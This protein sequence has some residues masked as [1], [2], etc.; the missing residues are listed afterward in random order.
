MNIATPGRGAILEKPAL[1]RTGDPTRFGPVWRWVRMS[2]LCKIVGQNPQELWKNFECAS[3]DVQNHEIK[4]SAD[5]EHLVSSTESGPPDLIN[6]GDFFVPAGWSANILKIHEVGGVRAEVVRHRCNNYAHQCPD[7]AIRCILGVEP[8]NNYVG[9]AIVGYQ[10]DD[11]PISRRTKSVARW[12]PC[13]CCY[14]CLVRRKV[15]W[16]H[17]EKC[18]L[19]SEDGLK[20]FGEQR[21]SYVDDHFE[22][23]ILI[24][25]QA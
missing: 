10:P 18:R 17:R 9:Y 22:G 21:A 4:W 16:A 8:N 2:E 7:G 14:H 19:P 3:D 6:G 15:T 13:P 1:F 24:Y 11:S 20:A 23:P 12:E 5:L 25:T